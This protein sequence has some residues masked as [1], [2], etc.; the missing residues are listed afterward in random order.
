MIGGASPVRESCAYFQIC[1]VNFLPAT[2]A[3]VQFFLNYKAVKQLII[4]FRKNI[5][6]ILKILLRT[7]FF[8]KEYG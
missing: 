6:C 2:A 7:N 3:E 5:M 4:Y 8:M 1:D